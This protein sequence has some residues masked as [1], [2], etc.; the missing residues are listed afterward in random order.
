MKYCS[1]CIDPNTRPNSKL[2]KKGL[3]LSCEDYLKTDVG[4]NETDRINILKE[5]II[6]YKPEKKI[7]FDCIIG[8]SGGKDSTRQALWLRDKFGLNPLLVCCTYP[9]EQITEIGSNNLSNLINLGF[10]VLITGPS[11]ETYKKILKKGFFQGNYLRGPELA[12]YS[13][14]PQIAIKYGIKLIFWGANPALTANDQKTNILTAPYDG[15]N[16]R[17]ANTLKNCD[18][19]WMKNIAP[20]NK[21]FPYQYPLKKEFKEKNIQIIYLGWFWNNWS[22]IN[23]AKFSILNGLEIRKDKVSN[24]G[25]LYGSMALDDDWV[26]LNQMIKYYKFGLGRVTDYLNFEI[27][28]GNISRKK[29]I[30]IAEKYDGNCSKKY[31]RS[32]CKYIGIK[33]TVFWK[34]IDKFMN[35]KLFSFNNNYKNP[36]IKRKFKV[37]IGL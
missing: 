19:S 6:K 9:P 10:N 26:T 3:C 25:D 23:N 34:T 24:T 16:L 14:V 29:S 17:N 4:F 27:R 7:G 28:M 2:N 31:I 5:I 35:K 33:E 20:K 13:S 21:I 30:E 12:L 8:I 36:K 37:G 11:P 1:N 32:F 15:N 18:I 22:I